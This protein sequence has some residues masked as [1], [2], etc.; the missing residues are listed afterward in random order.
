MEALLAAVA[1]AKQGSNAAASPSAGGGGGSAS[2]SSLAFDAG[3]AYQ[4]AVMEYSSAIS[5][6]ELAQAAQQKLDSLTKGPANA[7]IVIDDDKKK[8]S[9]EQAVSWKMGVPEPQIAEQWQKDAENIAAYQKAQTQQKDGESSARSS[10]EPGCDPAPKPKAKAM[11]IKL[12]HI[13]TFP[14][15]TGTMEIFARIIPHR[16][17]VESKPPQALQSKEQDKVEEVAK[18]LQPRGP[19]PHLRQI[20]PPPP[21]V[22]TYGKDGTHLDCYGSCTFWG[23]L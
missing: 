9:A 6:L 7:P 1:A 11:P 23:S 17:D 12:D 13:A 10:A 3:Q 22:P 20:C 2:A 15:P 4:R 21:P 5:T 19:P 16:H 8:T 14:V 18:P